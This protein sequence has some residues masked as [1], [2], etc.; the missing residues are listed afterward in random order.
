MSRPVTTAIERYGAVRINPGKRGKGFRI[1]WTDAYGRQLEKT[2]TTIEAARKKAIDATTA[3]GV[4]QANGLFGA[5]VARWLDINESSWEDRHAEDTLSAARNHIIPTVGHRAC[6]TLTD[7]DFTNVLNAMAGVPYAAETI[8]RVRRVLKNLGQYGV[9]QG[10]WSEARNPCVALALPKNARGKDD[11]GR[12]TTIDRS[13]QVPTGDQV[14][15]LCQQLDEASPVYGLMARLAAS[16]GLRW[17][18]LIALT[19]DDVD[20]ANRTVSVTKSFSET[21]HGIFSKQPKTRAGVR[22]AV[23]SVGLIPALKSHMATLAAGDL[24]FTGARGGVFRRSNWS[25]RIFGPARAKCSYPA[26]LVWHSLRHYAI[27]SWI[28]AGVPVRVCSRMAGHA[29]THTT[30]VRYVGAGSDYL[31]VAKARI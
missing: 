6:D 15:D 12:I 21:R 5:L 3:D 16:T 29:S 17:G 4:V 26:H 25:R 10:V 9:R 23:F 18:E 7:K 31:D 2:A 11:V 27:S 28:D 1:L 30:L 19:V 8:N 14:T 24:L 13:S 22:Q 20:L